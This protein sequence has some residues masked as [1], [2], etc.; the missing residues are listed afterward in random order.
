MRAKEERK[1]REELETTLK[2]LE[3]SLSSEENQFLYDKCSRD[4]EEI[5]DNIAEGI[6]IRSRCQ[7]YEEGEKS[8]KFFLSLKKFN[9]MQ[10][11]IRQIIVNDQ[12]KLILI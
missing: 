3:K 11:Q 12:E 5:Y 2:L 6:R 4:L 8:S 7:W 9:G 1:Q 10:S